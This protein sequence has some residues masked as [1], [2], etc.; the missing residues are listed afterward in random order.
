MASDCIE[1]ASASQAF[2]LTKCTMHSYTHSVSAHGIWQYSYMSSPMYLG[3]QVT[4]LHQTQCH[5]SCMR[6]TH[7]NYTIHINTEPSLTN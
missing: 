2:N 7:V 5:C 4:G 1:L 6:E 3:Y